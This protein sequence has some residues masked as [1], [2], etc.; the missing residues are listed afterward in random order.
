MAAEAALAAMVQV[1]LAHKA[2]PVVLDEVAISTCMT[3]GIRRTM[4]ESLSPR[5]SLVVSKSTVTGILLMG[6]GGT[7]PVEHIGRSQGKACKSNYLEYKCGLI[8]ADSL[9]L[10][11]FLREKLIERLKLEEAALE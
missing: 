6:M 8:C 2:V 5:T 9:G 10:S 1:E 11:L 4:D 3:I 7:R